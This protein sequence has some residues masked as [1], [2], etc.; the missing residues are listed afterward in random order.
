M[1]LGHAIKTQCRQRANA[2]A[3]TLGDLSLTYAQLSAR[4]SQTDAALRALATRPHTGVA[5]PAHG[6]VFAMSLG[7]APAALPL[8]ATALAT[9][10]AAQVMDPAWPEPLLADMLIAL[11]P[12][13]LFCLPSQILLIKTAKTL[14]IPA[15][16]DLEAFMTTAAVISAADSVPTSPRHTLLIGFTSGTTS[17]PKAFARSRQSWRASLDASRDAFATT[18]QSHTIAPGP[19]AHGV[20]LYAL[21]ETLDA[22]AAFHAL[23]RFSGPACA[24][25]LTHTSRLVAVPS[26]LEVLATHTGRKFPAITNVTTAG[27]KL[28][29]TLLARLRTTFP[30][31]CVYEYYG[32]SELG[33]VS[34]NRHDAEKSSGSPQSVGRPF[35][36]VNLSIRHKDRAVKTGE[37]GTIHVRSNLAIDGYLLGGT[38][39]GFR[40]N[41]NWATVGDL[42]RIDTDGC[43]HLMGREGGMIITGGHNVYPQEVETVL[44]AL[45]GVT[46]AV[47]L[48]VPDTTRGQRLVALVRGP[49]TLADLRTHLNTHLPRYK[50]P[51]SF[52][53]VDTWPLTTSG[54]IARATLLER[55]QQ[56]DP[57]L[58]PLTT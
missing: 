4:I 15:I 25:A 22:G 13:I 5:L 2:L 57:T 3:V 38:A 56:K 23:P 44:T 30:K 31:A 18:P 32:A 35:P 37:T 28:D 55:L 11:P 39:S 36:H 34:L 20:T 40:Q 53:K 16:T 43:L 33:F 41:G 52:Y 42:G 21:A 48:G 27:A 17:R 12:D 46:G 26:M 7:N 6:R 8:L 51:R 1:P 50:I 45:A 14:G 54:K 49:A 47:V 9:G 19:L 24:A 58:V 10:H 29:P